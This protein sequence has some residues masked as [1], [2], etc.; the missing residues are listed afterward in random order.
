MFDAIAP[1]Y[2][3][4]NR[5]MTL[6]L[7]Q[8]WRRATVDALG[9][10][11]G[12]LVLDLACGTGDLSELARR[13]GYRSI[14]ADL[15]WGMLAARARPVRSC[16]ATPPTCR[17]PPPR[18]DGVVCGYA[19][20]NFTDLAGSLHEAARVLRPGGR[21]AV[22]E[23]AAPPSGVLR[24]GHRLWFERVVPAIG[25]LLSDA[26]AYRYLPRSTAYL[27]DEVPLRGLFLDAGFSAVGRRPPARRAQPADHR[28]PRRLAR[29]HRGRRPLGSAVTAPGPAGPSGAAVTTSTGQRH[30]RHR[31]P[32]LPDPNT[33]RAVTVPLGPEPVID[34]YALAGGRGVLFADARL[35]LAGRGVAAVLELPGGLLDGD[36]LAA[37]QAWLAAVPHT[38]RVGRPGSKVTALGALPFD[39]SAAGRLVVPELAVGRDD[40][41][42]QWVTLIAPGPAGPAQHRIDALGDEVA[43]LC[44]STRP[45]PSPGEPRRARAPPSSPRARPDPTTPGRWPPPWPGSPTATS[46]RSS[47]P[48][49]SRPRFADVVTTTA[50][51]RR[52]HDQEPS[53]TIFAFPA[54]PARGGPADGEGGD[55]RFLGASPELLVERRGTVVTCH[56]LAGTVGLDDRGITD[57]A[58]PA[59]R[60]AGTIARFLASAKD[61][62]EH[63]LV[64]DEI[65]AR[66]ATPVRRSVGARR[67]LA[68]PAA[69][70]G[71]PRHRGV[72]APCAPIGRRRPSARSSSCW[73]S[74]TRPRPS[75]ACRVTAALACIAQ[76]ETGPRG[77]WAGPVGWVDAAGD[78]RWM[79]GIRSATVR[80]PG[81]P[82]HRRR[83]HR[84]RVRTP[85]GAGRDHGEAGPGP[86]RLRPGR[87]PACGRS[88]RA[89]A[90]AGVLGTPRR[91][92]APEGGTASIA[93][94]V[95]G[96]A[97]RDLHGEDGPLAG[98]RR[99]LGVA[100]RAPRRWP[101][102]WP[103]RGR[104]PARSAR[105]RPG[106]SGRRP[107]PRWRGAQARALVA[108]PDHPHPVLGRDR[109]PDRR[110]RAGCGRARCAPGCGPPGPAGRGRPPPSPVRRPPGPPGVRGRPPGRRPPRPGR[111]VAARPAPARGAGP[112]PVGPAAAGR[113][114]GRPSAPPRARPGPGPAAGSPRRRRPPCAA[115]RRTP[116][117][118]S[119]G[120]AAR[121]RRRP[122]TGAAGPR[123]P[124][125]RRTPPRSGTAWR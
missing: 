57:A 33:L 90:S 94:T 122:R 26:E 76:L 107:A 22:L 44:R 100:P 46:A 56:P 66:P 103:G 15:S 79:I 98:D 115:A 52:L 14:G 40:E 116:G 25:G 34:P 81:R 2:D 71:P 36:R 83:R 109:H 93:G 67:A 99:H 114:P 102:R 21:M 7:D 16:S 123:R 3:L 53:C 80:G 31:V 119:A 101:A 111:P 59:H 58:D 17:W 82:P 1:R 20:R 70:G 120:C 95:V 55:G 106:R 125:S 27:P 84:G 42:H 92:R 37:V 23:V 10:A 75:A 13:R 118:R 30:H 19:L 74:S 32:G 24:S 50:V 60:D 77:Q 89:D 117:W 9:L 78:G 112:G 47:W 61:R 97:Q 69:L 4:V 105:R 68:G 38:D 45:S 8:G 54:E 29:G 86:R 121:G 108:H 11:P 73:P 96:L 48:G 41:G 18:C 35:A 87:A 51:V 28:H 5:V 39:R 43:A 63:Q 113:R 49:A 88:G 12:A 104:C 62:V 72:G 6:G 124:T 110:A 64:V 65:V 91:R 85:G